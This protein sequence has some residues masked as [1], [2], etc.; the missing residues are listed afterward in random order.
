MC[1]SDLTGLDQQL[2]QRSPTAWETADNDLLPEW[3]SVKSSLIFLSS[4]PAKSRL[5]QRFGELKRGSASGKWLRGKIRTGI[6][7][8]PVIRGAIHAGAPESD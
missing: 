4:K 6:D 5:Q 3:D 2:Q 7:Q 1:S 8:Q